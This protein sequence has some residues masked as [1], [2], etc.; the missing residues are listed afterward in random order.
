MLAVCATRG[1]DLAFVH[2][3]LPLVG[4]AAAISKEDGMDLLADGLTIG[5][6]H[7]FPTLQAN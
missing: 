2:Q 1:A 3:A 6:F 5:G 7:S 4:V